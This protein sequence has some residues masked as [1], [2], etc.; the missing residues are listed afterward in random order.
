MSIRGVAMKA[1]ISADLGDPRLMRLLKAEAAE[2]NISVKEV[3]VRALEG[4]FSHRI[5]NKDIQRVAESAF[6]EW[7]DPRDAEY[8]KL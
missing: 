4:Y 5:E 7:R 6:N 1:R 8:D 3:L 2:K